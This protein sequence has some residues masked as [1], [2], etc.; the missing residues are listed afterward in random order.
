MAQRVDMREP[1]KRVSVDEAQKL[2]AEGIQI[3]DVR[4]PAE[5][6]NGHI[7]D[8]RS[9]P[10]DS[11]LA[12]PRDLL[13]GDRILFVCQVGQRSALAAEMAAA[14]GISEVFN[15]E[16]GTDAWVRAGNGVVR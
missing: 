2:I 8:A 14:V 11:V 7:P 16:G 4:T 3:V 5:Y 13:K 15:L 9:V 6:G 1:F 10:L 12:R